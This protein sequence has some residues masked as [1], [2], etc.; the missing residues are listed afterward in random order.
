VQSI[1][2]GFKPEGVLTMRT[3]LPMPAY[4]RV[5]TREAFYSRVL[6]EI[7]AVPGVT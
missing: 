5:A 2:P 4:G 6:R 7:R 3:E 1:D